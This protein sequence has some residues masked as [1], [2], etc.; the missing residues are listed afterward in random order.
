MAVATKHARLAILA[1]NAN[2][3]FRTLHEYSGLAFVQPPFVKRA[4]QNIECVS[5]N[6]NFVDEVL[7]RP[8]QRVIRNLLICLFKLALHRGKCRRAFCLGS[9]QLGLRGLQSFNS[10]PLLGKDRFPVA[11]NCDNFGL[12]FS[13]ASIRLFNGISHFK[14]LSC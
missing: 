10:F 3:L 11:L 7:N 12:K 14:I 8:I 1:S 5:F 2:R 9:L 13:D 4:E 6:G